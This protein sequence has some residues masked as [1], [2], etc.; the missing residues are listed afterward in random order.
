LPHVVGQGVWTSSG[1]RG[2]VVEPGLPLVT[3]AAT[4]ETSIP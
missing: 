1:T 3:K 4:R 2:T